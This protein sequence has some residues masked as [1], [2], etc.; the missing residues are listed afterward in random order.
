MALLLEESVALFVC[1]ISFV[2]CLN[3][4]FINV[5]FGLEKDFVRLVPVLLIDDISLPL[6]LDLLFL[7]AQLAIVDGGRMRYLR[8][9]LGLL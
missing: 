1:S 3:L 9:T 7:N 2:E 5:I 6:L 8:L 4:L